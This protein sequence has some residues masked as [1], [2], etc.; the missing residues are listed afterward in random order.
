MSANWVF[1]AVQNERNQLGPLFLRQLSR[2]RDGVFVIELV[3]ETLTPTKVRRCAGC[4]R[5]SQDRADEQ[6]RNHG[7]ANHAKDHTPNYPACT[8]ILKLGQ[9]GRSRSFTSAVPSLANS[10]HAH[11]PSRLAILSAE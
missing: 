10:R 1:E 6:Q 8:A 9:S 11:Q 7:P 4:G 2:S 3:R 5:L